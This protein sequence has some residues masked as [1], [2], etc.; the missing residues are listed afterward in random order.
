[1][2]KNTIKLENTVEKIN[3]FF[4][5]NSKIIVICSVI[6]L[7]INIVDIVTIKFGID[8]EH[9]AILGTHEMFKLSGRFG[10]YILNILFPI[11]SYQIISQILGL[12]C[13]II[14][15]LIIINNYNFNNIEKILFTL[16]FVTYP[17]AAYMQYYY[18][19]S[20]YI[21]FSILLTVISYK[22]LDSPSIIYRIFSILILTFSISVFQANVAIFLSV[23]AIDLILQHLN[24]GG[25]LKNN[26]KKLCKTTTIAGL[27][28][29]LYF[30]IQNI[31]LKYLWYT[32]D[33][34]HRSMIAYGRDDFIEILGNI[35][36]IIW[37]IMVGHHSHWDF[38]AYKYITII[39]LISLVYYIIKSKSLK[40]SITI[41]LYL[42]LF[43]ASVFSMIILMGTWIGSR[44]DLSVGFYGATIILILYNSVKNKNIKKLL[45]VFGIFVILYHGSF[46]VKY[47]TASY[48]IYTQDKNTAVIILNDL[49]KNFPEIYKTN[50]KII[51]YGKIDNNDL[52]LIQGD[53][54]FD[55][56]SPFA[57]PFKE[58]R[59][60]Y[61]V[62]FLK[63]MGLPSHINTASNN[64]VLEEI[65]HHMPHYPKNGYIG[66]YNDIIIINLQE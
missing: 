17:S 15:G 61:I 51:T 64:D 36:T 6:V 63:I 38:S 35:F 44:I 14:T 31:I 9:T 60:N 47:Q 28:T 25:G 32:N 33:E 59:P 45:L 2:K 24:L 62:N 23:M 20:F 40:K 65:A 42:C 21:F 1:M 66:I 48:M 29:I 37:R 56:S 55:L 30:I 57:F 19:Q 54:V 18:F 4:K 12:L 7:I 46:I 41:I 39:M 49:Y 3:I 58:Y 27:S 8:S 53:G 52:D 16:L 26:L 43:L 11:G 50:Y 13:L 5:N 34:Y 10:L 22:L